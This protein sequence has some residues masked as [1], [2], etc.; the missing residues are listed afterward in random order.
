MMAIA[1]RIDALP[2]ASQMGPATA[3][4]TRAGLQPVRPSP[5]CSWP[6]ES[7]Q[8]DWQRDRRLGGELS[9]QQIA[10]TLSMLVPREQSRSAGIASQAR[11]ARRR[12]VMVDRVG[13]RVLHTEFNA[14]H[15]ILH[16]RSS[17]EFAMSGLPRLML[18]SI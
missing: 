7:D 16:T 1:I 8:A 2:S 3:R 6:E 10:V 17:A 11:S 15:C 13:R 18:A 4:A 14:A 9:P 12:S 5:P